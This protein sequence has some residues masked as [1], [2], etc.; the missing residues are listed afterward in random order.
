MV[1]VVLMAYGIRLALG[2]VVR[3][4]VSGGFRATDCIPVCSSCFRVKVSYED[5]RETGERSLSPFP[6]LTLLCSC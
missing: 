5:M 3:E 2:E 6:R 4:R 1:A